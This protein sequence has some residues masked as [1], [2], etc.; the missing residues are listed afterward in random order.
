[1]TF[2]ANTRPRDTSGFLI[3]PGDY[4]VARGGHVRVGTVFESEDM[5]LLVRFQGEDRVQRVDELS[6][7]CCWAKAEQSELADDATA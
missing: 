4:R 3:E 7:W 2:N 5:D 6:Q 1:M